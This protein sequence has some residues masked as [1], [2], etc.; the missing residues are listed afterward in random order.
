MGNANL[1]PEQTT[2]YELGVKHQFANDLVLNVTGFFKDI[3]GLTDTRQIYYSAS[4][5]YGIYDNTDYG[6][7][8]GF[9]VTVIRPRH[10]YLSG[11]ATYTYSFARGKNSSPTADYVTIWEGNNVPTTETFLDWDQ[12]H[13][14][15]ANVDLRTLDNETFFGIPHTDNLGF[16]F[17]IEYGSGMPWSPPTRDQDK[18]KYENTERMPYTLNVDMIADKGFRWNKLYT[19]VFIEVRNL[20]NKLNILDIDDEEWY[21]LQ[22]DENGNRI[23]DADG[24]YDNPT[25]YGQERLIRIGAKF[26]F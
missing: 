8:R 7:V 5:W 15:T 11:T 4:N 26:E 9:E 25:V 19:K 6:N 23:Y 18:W 16:N 13:T 12:R 24:P 1:E 2:S 10:R 17:I 3:T 22:V 20:F 14:I 21:A